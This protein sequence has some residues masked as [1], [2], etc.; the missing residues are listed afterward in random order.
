[1]TKSERR[2]A[3][4]CTATFASFLYLEARAIYK[5]KPQDTLTHFLRKLLGIDPVKPWRVLGVSI[6]VG[7]CFWLAAHLATGKLVPKILRTSG[8][9]GL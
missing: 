6:L 4:W 1:M 5:R 2:W 9:G 7:S 8:K 3:V